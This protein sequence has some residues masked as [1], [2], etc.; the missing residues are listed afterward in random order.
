ME[1]V[2]PGVKGAQTER[3]RWRGEGREG[4]IDSIG[5]RRKRERARW[6]E[7]SDGNNNQS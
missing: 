1:S 3:V 6:E 4:G 5:K 7:I 2:V